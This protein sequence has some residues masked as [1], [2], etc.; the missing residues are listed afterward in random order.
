[1]GL[2]FEVVKTFFFFSVLLLHLQHM[3]VPRIGVE[4]ELQLQAYTAARAM[5]DLSHIC[6]LCC[7]YN[8][9][10]LTQ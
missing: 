7:S 4:L 2:I 1:M 3:E 6:N 9:R 5:W 10:S 8:T